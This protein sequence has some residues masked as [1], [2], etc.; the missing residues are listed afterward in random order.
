MKWNP[1]VVAASL[2][3][4]A[5]AQSPHNAAAPPQPDTAMGPQEQAAIKAQMNY[6]PW[7]GR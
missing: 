1:I 6:Q 7:N 5:R 2:G 4:V 3:I